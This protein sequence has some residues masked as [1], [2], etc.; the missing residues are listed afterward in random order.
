MK[1]TLLQRSLS[2]GL[3]TVFL[4]SQVWATCGGGGGG[5]MGGMAGGGGGSAQQVYMV[6]WKLV[7]AEDA[8]I[9]QGLAV[10]WIPSGPDEVTKS[11]LRESRTLQ[12]YSQQCVS[13]GLVDARSPIGQKYVPDGKVPAVVM[14][15]PDGT[16][17]GKLDSKD[18]KLRVGDLEKLVD[19]Q[20]KKMEDSLK[21]RTGKRQEQGQGW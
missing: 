7:K 2:L 16:V 20:M 9:K 13:M 4:A 14:V 18:G 1:P 11:S 3:I 10:Y 19:N 6:P 5:G 15:Q 8:P 21:E 12:M 17:V